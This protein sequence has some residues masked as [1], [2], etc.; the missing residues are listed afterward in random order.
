MA[1]KLFPGLHHLPCFALLLVLLVPGCV[2]YL[3]HT[4]AAAGKYVEVVC[5]TRPIPSDKRVRCTLNV[6]YAVAGAPAAIE[7]AESRELNALMRRTID[8]MNIFP[9][10]NVGSKVE[11]PDYHFVFNVRIESTRKPCVFSGL[12]LPFYRTREYTVTLQILDEKGQPFSNYA[13]SSEVSETRHLF[14]LPFTPFFWPARTE[15]LARR[16]AFEALSVKLV[17]DRK[18]FL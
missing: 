1:G 6:A 10:K 18:E 5:A 2:G 14:L 12:I 13:A 15:A 17:T 9:V 7:R 11:R 4:D 3:G 16:S 8:D